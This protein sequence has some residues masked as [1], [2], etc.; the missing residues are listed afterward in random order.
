[1]TGAPRRSGTTPPSFRRV[2][3]WRGS[4]RS[5][6]TKPGRAVE[7][8][9]REFWDEHVPSL[10][11]CLREYERGPDANM[12]ALLDALEPLGGA[13]V[14]DFACGAGVT[15]AWLAARGADVVGIDLSPRSV[16]RAAELAERVGAR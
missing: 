2:A 4:R 14:L 6:P 12:R 1:M 9:E 13:A 15:S 16:E 10:D 7:A 3:S 5:S 11:R 8:R